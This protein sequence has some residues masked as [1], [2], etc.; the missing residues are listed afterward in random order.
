MNEP[1]GN[2]RFTPGNQVFMRIRLNDGADGITAVNYLTTT[3]SATVLTFGTEAA[4]EQ[5][6]AIRA[7]SDASSKN[8]V[9]LYDNTTG[10][11]RPLYGTS[12]ET[13]GIDYTTLTSISEFYRLLVS[14]VDGSWGGIVPN[15]NANGVRLVEERS[16]ADGSIVNTDTSADGLWGTT[17]TVNPTGGTT[18]VLV[19][20]LNPTSDPVISVSP[21]TLSNFTYVVGYGPSDEQSFSIGGQNLTTN[22][23]IAG[24][25]NYEISTGTGD[26]FVATDPIELTQ[27]GGVVAPTT[28]YVRLKAGLVPGDYSGE[29][30]TATAAGAENKTVTLNGSVVPEGVG[31]LLLVEN[32][33]YTIGTNLTDNG[34]VAHSGEGNESPTV[35]D[36]L[37]FAGYAGT[38][39]GGAALLDNTG[40]DVHHTFGE[41]NT[42]AVYAAFIVNP[43]ANASAGYFIHFGQTTIGTTYF[44]RIW[45]NETADG[46]GIGQSAPATYV[47]ITVGQPTLGVMKFDFASMTSSLFVFNSFPDAEPALADADFVETGGF[48]NVGSI[49]LRQFNAAEHIIV[50]GIRVATS[51]ED[52]VAASGGAPVVASPSFNPPAGNYFDPIDVTISTVTAGATLYYSETSAAGPWT[53]YTAPLNLAVGT[54]LWAYGEKDGYDNSPVSSATYTFTGATQVATIAELRLG[55]TDGTI[56]ELTGEAILT[57]QSSTRNQKFIQDATAAIM[58]DDSPGVITTVYG[59]YDGITGITGTLTLY[60]NM[61]EFVPTMDPGA[62]TSTGNTVTPVEVSL[63]DLDESYQAQLVKVTFVDFVLDGMFVV[64]T[65]YEITDPAGAGVFRTQY[66]DVDYIGT[67]IPANLQDI[68]G[69]MLQY[70]TTMQ[71]VARSLAD[72]SNSAT[73]DPLITATPSTLNDFTYIEGFGPSVSQTYALTGSNL[74]GSG[75]IA[76]TAPVDYEISGND[77]N[78]TGSLSIPFADGV[79]T[80]QPVTIYVRLKA[81]LAPGLYEAETITHTGGD[82]PEVLVTL[83]G[84]VTVQSAAT[85]SGQTLPQYIEGLNGTNNDRIPFAFSATLTGLDPN[86]TY[87]YINQVVL[88]SDAPETNGAGNVIFASQAGD[89]IRT[90]S[91]A[92]DTDGNYGVLTTDVSGSFTGWFVTEPTGNARFTPGNHVFMRI[93]LNDGNDGITAAHLLTTTDSTKVLTFGVEAIDNQGT[94]LRAISGDSPK[95][96]VFLYDNLSGTGR[97]LYGTFIETSGIDFSAITQYATFFKDFVAGVNGSWGAIIPNVNANGVQL[98]QV[99]DLANGTVEKSYTGADGIW[100]TTETVNPS[101]GTAE[102]LVI[103]LIEIGINT[104]DQIA[105]RVWASN[106]ELIVESNTDSQLNIQIINLLG[107]PVF[108]QEIGGIG[109]HRLFHHLNTGVYIISLKTI[110]GTTNSKIIIR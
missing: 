75:S 94:A 38:D 95:D 56:Y 101:G 48:T 53:L 55:A 9:F 40:E 6:T 90:T 8:I 54:T 51:W 81:D 96:F 39:V 108:N 11:G 99:L 88:S 80:G 21:T 79:I 105:C 82:A 20:I 44:T 33:E 49:A 84:E 7:E 60:N 91:P 86:K 42:G 57:F 1:S 66:G 23:S 50:D 85:I 22:I 69:V 76:I 74:V 43:T 12:I 3:A 45:L 83:N 13:V 34:W 65:N 27:T 67:I 26:S 35:T 97:P 18:N 68:T 104:N 58:I 46:L 59:L 62:A 2:A 14:G 29:E 100:G 87:R 109:I 15:I 63:N 16:L 72:F 24:S 77:V 103:D 30:L 5:G 10:T 93:R 37:S 89:F 36:G 25:A 4:A 106:N 98:V 31:G 47:P 110:N 78:Y 19:L 32:F 107:Q 92:F 71:L 17:N 52:A 73:T 70:Q 64:S 28:I 102:V 41:Q 61:L